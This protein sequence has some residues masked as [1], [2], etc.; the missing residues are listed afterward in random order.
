MPLALTESCFIVTRPLVER[1]DLA[2]ALQAV[3]AEVLEFPAQELSATDDAP[4]PGPFDLAIFTSPAA[5]EFGRER[6]ARMLP[7]RL[8]APGQGTARRVREAGLGKAI[9]P[10][11]GAGLAALLDEPRLAERLPGQ[12]VLVVGGRPLKR[13]SLEQLADRGAQAVGFCA[14]E[15]LPVRDPEPLA[16][17]LARRAPDAI[18]VSSVSAVQALTALQGIAWGDTVWIVSSA[19]VGAAVEAGGARVGAVAASAGTDDMVRAAIEWYSAGGG[20]DRAD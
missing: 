13:H 17:W 10:H 8:A 16:G 6:L 2:E 12:R 11:S 18:M 7:A 9:A 15:R 1:G 20:K 4:P 5:V 19:R 3:G 14:Y